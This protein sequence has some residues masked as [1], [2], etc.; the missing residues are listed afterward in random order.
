MQKTIAKLVAGVRRELRAL[1][2][3]MP[4]AWGANAPRRGG[5][6]THLPDDNL[7]ERPGSL[8]ITSLP[9]GVPHRHPDSRRT[10]HRAHHPAHR[11]HRHTHQ[12]TGRS[13]PNAGSHRANTDAGPDQP[14]TR[15]DALTNGCVAH[16]YPS[17]DTPSQTHSHAH[18][19]ATLGDPGAR[20]LPAYRGIRPRWSCALTGTIHHCVEAET[21]H[22]VITFCRGH[23]WR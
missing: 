11:P 20:D 10:D 5:H 19:A 12:P 13:H 9:G 3:L 1:G 18:T 23:N 21:P 7:R 15:G 8:S 22:R 17:A 14:A 16:I 2:E 4:R 6:S